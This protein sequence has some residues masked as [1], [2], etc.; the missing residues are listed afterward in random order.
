MDWIQ[1]AQ[2]FSNGHVLWCYEWEK[3]DKEELLKNSYRLLG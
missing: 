2:C 1:N 3:D